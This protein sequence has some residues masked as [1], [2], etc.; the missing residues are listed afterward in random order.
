LASRKSE[1]QASVSVEIMNGAALLMKSTPL[2][3]AEFEVRVKS[4]VGLWLM[5]LI[6]GIVIH[7]QLKT[8]NYGFLVVAKSI[9]I[10]NDWDPATSTLSASY[11]KV[12]FEGYVNFDAGAEY[13]FTISQTGEEC[14]AGSYRDNLKD[15]CWLL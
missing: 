7:T 14:T 1:N 2:L 10:S 15:S 13:K 8:L 11:G 3:H 6:V 12:D 9:W 4:T 5:F